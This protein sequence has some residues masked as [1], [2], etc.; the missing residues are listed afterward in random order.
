MLETPVIAQ[1]TV[2]VASDHQSPCILIVDDDPTT[3]RV[4]ES[5]LSR[6][7]F[8]TLCAHDLA[9]AEALVASA[10]IGLILLDVHLPD[11][12]GLE[13]CERMMSGSA[14]AGLPILFI[15]AND[16]LS[17]KVRG[18]AA[19]AVDYIAKPL[20]GA[21]V[22]ARVRTHLRLRAAYDTLV[23]LQAERIERLASSQQSLMPTPADLPEAGFQ[24]CVRQALLAGGD[25]YDVVPTG[26]QIT[27]FVVAD[28]SGHDL[29]VS[30]W[31]ASFKTL[32]AEY[33]SVVLEPREIFRMVNRSLRRVLPEG[34]YFT[35]VYAR[36]NRATNRVQLASAGH[37]AAV[38]LT[39]STGEI[40]VVQQEGDIVGMF[41]DAV[42]DQRE[43]AVQPG[44]RLF[45]YTD[46]LIE[47]DATRD[48]GLAALCRAC[49]ATA[50][51]PLDAAVPAMVGKVGVG[52]DMTDD[53]VLLGVEV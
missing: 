5:I 20:A 24:V 19:G 33:A 9:G 42:F 28:A 14:Q 2:V 16:D 32:L 50:S 51:S 46:G 13:F 6:A 10:P 25:F 41:S 29:G 36:L 17:A 30:L 47:M 34:S 48:Q 43:V 44:D 23:T 27:D 40:R 18:F 49:R 7:G 8:D 21:E 11:G 39:P 45:L 15:S 38:I 4:L 22:L 35:A 37:P 12:N 31:T 52:K 1:P 53:I 26:H 3:T